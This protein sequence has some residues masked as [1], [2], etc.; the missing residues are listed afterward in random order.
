MIPMRG[1]L[2]L[3]RGTKGEVGSESESRGVISSVQF[4]PLQPS[5]RRI[6]STL[7]S[8]RSDGMYTR[9]M[10]LGLLI[11]HPCSKIE[12]MKTLRITRPYLER[13]LSDWSKLSLIDVRDISPLAKPKMMV[14]LK[15]RPVIKIERLDG[16]SETVADTHGLMNLSRVLVSSAKT[17]LLE[18]FSISNLTAAPTVGP[19]NLL[20]SLL[21]VVGGS[22]QALYRHLRDLLSSGLVVKITSND[23][24]PLASPDGFEQGRFQTTEKRGLSKRPRSAFRVSFKSV[25]LELQPY[26]Y[27]S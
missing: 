10:F 13:I 1:R 24:A 9:F 17:R 12:A 7:S 15:M 23:N 2:A 25:K 20:P 19:G 16:E 11:E 6:L 8:T 21:K 14:Y 18:L 3:K 22:K 5:F 27:P 4:T 26:R